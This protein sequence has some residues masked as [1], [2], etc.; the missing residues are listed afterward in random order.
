M[1]LLEATIAC[2]LILEKKDTLLPV[3]SQALTELE[4]V[5]PVRS[6]SVKKA[7]TA[8]PQEK[9]PGKVEHPAD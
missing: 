4:A 8:L 6:E 3:L 5:Q 7:A 2:A 9:L 1:T